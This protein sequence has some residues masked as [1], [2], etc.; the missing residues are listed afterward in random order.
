M[1]WWV[2]RGSV[3]YLFNFISNHNSVLG[4]PIVKYVEYL[5]NFI[6]NHN[7]EV[8]FAA[9]PTLNIF[10]ILYQTTTQNTLY[11]LFL[12]LNIFSILYQTTTAP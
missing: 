7:I 1:V 3:E 10:S 5:F 6:S 11:L 8:K 12:K 4:V 2:V 9:N